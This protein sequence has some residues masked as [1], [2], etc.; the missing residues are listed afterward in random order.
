MFRFSDCFV[1]FDEDTPDSIK[2]AAQKAVNV[3]LIDMVSNYRDFIEDDVDTPLISKIKEY[4]NGYYWKFFCTKIDHLDSILKQPEEITP[5][6]F[7]EAILADMFAVADM[8]DYDGT[9]IAQKTITK[10]QQ[11]ELE[12]F[13]LDVADENYDIVED[14]FDTIEEYAEYLLELIY[15]PYKVLEDEA[16]E[17]CG[18]VFWDYDFELFFENN[19]DRAIEILLGPVGYMMGYHPED[20]DNMLTTGNLPGVEERTGYKAEEINRKNAL[21]AAK[22]NDQIAE[23]VE[24]TIHPS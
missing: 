19:F 1:T 11:K 22:I 24:K 3:V 23:A 4:K 9:E 6:V 15:N 17:G 12:N 8:I 10:K 16:S 5:D 21:E 20:I 13:L 18:Y 2:L 14:D 7:E